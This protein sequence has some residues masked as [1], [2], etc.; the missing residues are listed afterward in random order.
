M[1]FKIVDQKG[2]EV[3]D[4]NLS[5]DIFKAPLKKEVIAQYVYMFLSNKRQSNAHTKDRSEV[6]GGGKKPHRQKGTGRARSG[7]SRNPIWTGGGVTFGPTNARNWKKTITKKFKKAVLR[8]VMSNLAESKSFVIVD[9]ISLK[10]DKPLTKQAEDIKT[11]ITKDS[12]KV[13]I[14]TDGNDDVVFNAF[15]NIS[16]VR[17]VPSTEMNAYDLITGG[18]V[19]FEEKAIESIQ[20]K[21]KK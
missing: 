7:S 21:L 14:V 9:D 15:T 4:I 11:K 16:N 10:E 6:S 1:K 20:N 19:V 3:K 2:K 12:R 18:T 8:Q 5:D 13:L 17:V